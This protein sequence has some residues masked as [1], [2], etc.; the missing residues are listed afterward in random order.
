MG[1]CYMFYHPKTLNKIDEGKYSGMPFFNENVESYGLI[2]CALKYGK[3]QDG[4]FGCTD[5][6]INKNSEIYNYIYS[7]PYC[8]GWTEYI[9]RDCALKMQEDMSVNKTLFTDLMDNY[10]CDALIMDV[11]Y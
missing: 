5:W 11:S 3:K 6:S 10:K 7:D 8:S 9:T 2:R 4:T 1:I